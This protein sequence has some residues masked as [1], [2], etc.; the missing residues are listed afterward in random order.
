MKR[1]IL[2]ITTLTIF[3]LTLTGCTNAGTDTSDSTVSEMV[4]IKHVAGETEIPKDPKRIAVLDLAILDIIDQLDMG[5]RVVGIPK[6]S[7]VEYLD[8]YISDN[9]IVNLGSLKEIDLEALNSLKPDVIFIGGRLSEQYE[10][11]S[12]IAPTLEFNLDYTNGYMSSFT[13]NVESISEIF[14]VKSKVDEFISDFKSRLEKLKTLASGKSAIVGLVTSGSLNTLGNGSRGSLITNE[15]GFENV[16]VDVDS[17]HGNTS[18]F[19]L[20]LQKNPDYIFIIDR[21]TAITAEGAKVAR[22]VMEN[23]I[24]MKTNAYQNNQ[25]VYLDPSAWYITEGGITATDKMIKDLEQGI[26]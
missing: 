19:E 16:A 21:D 18:S 7:S 15:V 13:S 11:I 22:E 14:G 25:I 4:K 26:K 3:S 20:L 12:V 8:K 10:D 2:L 9:N 1:L 24:V 17:T 5:N 6:K 23:E